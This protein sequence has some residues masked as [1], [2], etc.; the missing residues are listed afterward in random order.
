MSIM[1]SR[2][3][4]CGVVGCGIVA[5]NAYLPAIR[6]YGELVA[7]CDSI[8]ERAERSAK[9]W[10][11]KEYYGRFGEMIEKSDIEAVFILTGMGDHAK[12]V[13]EAAEAGKHILVQKPMATN[14][15][16]LRKAVDAVKRAGVKVLVEPGVQM[17]PVYVKAKEALK[18]IGDIY[19]FRA[20]LGR[21]P[22]VWGA[23]TF[24]SKEAGGPLFDLGVYEISALTFL[25][26]PVK[27]VAGLAKVSIPEINIVPPEWFTDYLS[28]APYRIVWE[29]LEKAPKTLR[30]RV[31]AEDNTLT[32]MEMETGSLG[33]VVANFVTP[34]GVRDDVGMLPDIEVYG[35][36]GGLLIGGAYALAYKDVKSGRGWVKVDWD[37]VGG[38]WWNYY[39]ASTKHFLGCIVKDEEP[40]PNIDWGAHVSEIMIK[41]IMSSRTNRI[42]EVETRF[43]P[44]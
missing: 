41:S 2:K 22:P 31:E 23:K 12:Q 9:L 20:G 26:G 24:F 27:R 35:S 38:R 19:W 4:K 10:G 28:K 17:F 7:V 18:S 13:V 36:N 16:D 32:L 25:L 14:M 29:A 6:E 42:M 30:I 11:A 39:A 43:K 33:V 34:D 21:G 5:N 37:S 40:I 44:Y 15:E 1:L 3:V 8:E